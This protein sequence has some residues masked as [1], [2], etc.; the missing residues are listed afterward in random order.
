MYAQ[1]ESALDASSMTEQTAHSVNDNSLEDAAEGSGTMP[2]VEAA[3]LGASS[4][5]AVVRVPTSTALSQ[6]DQIALRYQYQA[7]KMCQHKTT[8]FGVS[9]S[10]LLELRSARLCLQC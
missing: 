9:S 6:A 3:A 1:L 5:G 4:P 8:V 7:S 10:K 2:L